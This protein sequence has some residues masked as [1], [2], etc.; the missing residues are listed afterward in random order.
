MDIVL[1]LSRQARELWKPYCFSAARRGSYGKLG[2]FE[3]PGAGAM[4]NGKFTVYGATRE[5]GIDL[6]RWSSL[7]RVSR[8]TENRKQYVF[9]NSR[10]WRL[11][12][13][14]FSIARAPG[15]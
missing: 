1:F 10:A 7:I 12:N 2:G 9:H 4:E 6:K 11:K 8:V 14:T 5:S 3:P 13:I 15:G